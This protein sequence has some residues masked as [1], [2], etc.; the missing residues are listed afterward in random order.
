M[1]FVTVGGHYY[2]PSCR[3]EAAPEDVNENWEHGLCGCIVD[4]SEDEI[5]VE[6]EL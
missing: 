3:R 2:C 6:E 1:E 5:E 4:W